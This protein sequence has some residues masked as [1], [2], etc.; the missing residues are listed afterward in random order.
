MNSWAAVAKAGVSAKEDKAPSQPQHP[1]RQAQQQRQHEQRDRH[2]VEPRNELPDNNGTTVAILVGPARQDEPPKTVP[3]DSAQECTTITLQRLSFDPWQRP[4][5]NH[6]SSKQRIISTV[7]LFH[8][9]RLDPDTDLRVCRPSTPDFSN[10]DT[11]AQAS[12]PNG[13]S[14]G[15]SQTPNDPPG[16]AGLWQHDGSANVDAN[17][18]VLSLLDS[19]FDKGRQPD[20]IGSSQSLKALFSMPYTD[21]PVSVFIHRVGRALLVESGEEDPGREATHLLVV[22]SK[23]LVFQDP[24]TEAGNLSVRLHEASEQL[25]GSECLDFYLENRLAGVQ[26]FA[27]CLHSQGRV[28]DWRLYATEDIPRLEGHHAPFEDNRKLACS[29]SPQILEQRAAQLLAFLR[30]RLVDG[31]TYWLFKGANSNQVHLCQPASSNWMYSMAM[32]SYRMA[33]SYAQKR[34][35]LDVRPPEQASS[36]ATHAV[37]PPFSGKNASKR[38]KELGK[39]A[40]R[41]GGGAYKNRRA[42][43]N[44]GDGDGSDAK[45]TEKHAQ[46]LFFLRRE[47]ELLSKSIEILEEISTAGGPSRDLLQAS[48][49]EK[50]AQTFLDQV[51]WAQERARERAWK[52]TSPPSED[53]EGGV[54]ALVGTAVQHWHKAAARLAACPD[55]EA[56]PSE[57]MKQSMRDLQ[58]RLQATVFGCYMLTARAHASVGK[59]R[60]AIRTIT[61]GLSGKGTFDRWFPDWVSTHKPVDVVRGYS[62]LG[63]TLMG[64]CKRALRS[65]NRGPGPQSSVK[66]LEYSETVR[67]EVLACVALRGQSQA[68]NGAFNKGRDHG[69]DKDEDEVEN[70]DEDNDMSKPALSPGEHSENTCAAELLVRGALQVYLAA[71]TEAKR[72]ADQ[73][74][75]RETDWK[76]GNACNELGKLLLAVHALEA[77]KVALE[78]GVERFAQSDARANAIALLLNLNHLYRGLGLASAQATQKG[79]STSSSTSSSASSGQAQTSQQSSVQE[80]AP[81]SQLRE[82]ADRLRD[83]EA[84]I[85]KGTDYL[86]QARRLAGAAGNPAVELELAM[87][88]MIRGVWLRGHCSGDLE[89]L[90]P[91]ARRFTIYCTQE[92]ITHLRAALSRYEPLQATQ[93]VAVE[94]AAAVHYHLGAHFAWIAKQHTDAS[95]A[96]LTTTNRRL[97]RELAVRHFR[98]ALAG[99]PQG[100]SQDQCRSELAALQ[101]AARGA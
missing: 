7:Q 99:L 29:F 5:S 60:E 32:L 95:L 21:R 8:F 91:L 94:K 20:V 9:E 3:A 61:Q 63:D 43:G 87:N 52:Q 82:G 19:A 84:F 50:V 27:L 70:E 93:A 54:V 30:E 12:D 13:P 55:T 38:N 6:N 36:Q 85:Q 31:R 67:G 11:S 92:A 34:R 80:Q 33:L 44:G 73:A 88:E 4:N 51:P 1:A 77:A 25:S 18:E 48:L 74:L 15:K 66:W 100:A 89:T 71:H 56:L 17:T 68:S 79:K 97:T 35:K 98:Q 58:A 75:L 69:K 72:S 62:F 86:E 83:Q 26:R 45:D 101:Q 39:A 24:E 23:L 47:R 49:H 16:W 14:L 59:N 65:S 53:A 41:G 10:F 57:G 81:A 37:D 28:R 2:A 64:L 46:Y 40:R 96:A 78:A 42:H 22:G 90:D 76:L